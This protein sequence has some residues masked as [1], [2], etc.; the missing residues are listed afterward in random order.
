MLAAA[1]AVVGTR[2]R[3]SRKAR[4]W[5]VGEHCSVAFLFLFACCCCTCSCACCPSCSHALATPHTGC[6]VHAIGTGRPAGPLPAPCTA[7]ARSAGLTNCCVGWRLAC[8]LARLC[9]CCRRATR[10]PL[11]PCCHH[12]LEWRQLCGKQ[13]AARQWVGQACRTS[14]P[15]AALAPVRPARMA[16]QQVAVHGADAVVH[17]GREGRHG[18]R[19]MP[20]S[21][22]HSAYMRHAHGMRGSGP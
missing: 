13:H 12:G 7:R 10:S 4:C 1:L 8:R 11:S 15:T 21:S 16:A 3:A 5:Q 14:T 17:G 22:M 6:V 20:I 18:L 9:R 19:G 2:R